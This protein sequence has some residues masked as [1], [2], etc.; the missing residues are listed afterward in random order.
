MSRDKPPS[1]G[2]NTHSSLARSPHHVEKYKWGNV[3]LTRRFSRSQESDLRMQPLNFG[4]RVTGDDL[5]RSK[6]TSTLP[7]PPRL[8][9]PGWR[10]SKSPIPWLRLAYKDRLLLTNTPN[11]NHAIYKIAL[12]NIETFN[13]S[14]PLSD[15]LP[16]S[17]KH[18][19]QPFFQ[20]QIHFGCHHSWP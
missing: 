8:I 11:E 13:F 17:K 15:Y 7:N 14:L 20:P 3:S 9:G 12:Q 2:Y 16:L 18:V 1:G 4:L 6:M 10:S 5:V 19:H